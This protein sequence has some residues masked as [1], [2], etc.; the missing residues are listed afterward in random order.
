MKKLVLG[1]LLAVASA[2]TGCTSSDNGS[3]VDV[4]WTFKHL[5]DGGA[6]SCP[7]GY[8]TATIVS[9]RTDDSTHLGFGDKFV[10]KFD[11]AAGSGSIVL[12]DLDS[13]LVWVQIESDSGASVYAQ[14]NS[15]YVDTAL[16][17]QP[18]DVEILDDGGY[19]FFE[20]DVYDGNNLVSCATAGLDGANASVDS[21]ATSLSNSSY[22]RDD[23]FTCADHYG[24]TD[25]LL[26]GSYTVS[27]TAEDAAGVIGQADTLTN[28]VIAA[29]NKLTDLGLVK[30]HLD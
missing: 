12:P 11:C 5:A 19:F 14:S 20:W 27:I 1:A 13:Y 2:A 15:T 22:F 6:R 7:V 4:G 21:V 9:Q 25:G 3:V 16:S 24:T 29:P 23:K 8:D 30:I 18:V 10:D 28:K 26:A 17:Y